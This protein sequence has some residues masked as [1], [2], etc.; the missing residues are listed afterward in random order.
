[1]YKKK[2]ETDDETDFIENLKIN[3]LFII[4]TVC[5]ESFTILFSAIIIE[6]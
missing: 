1:M 2:S 4:L 3:K 6:S 5:T